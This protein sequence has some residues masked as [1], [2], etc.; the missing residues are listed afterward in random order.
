VGEKKYGGAVVFD[1]FPVKDFREVVSFSGLKECVDEAVS[2]VIAHELRGAS[3]DF[4]RRVV[5]ISGNEVYQ[6]LLQAF[7][8]S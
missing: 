3:D 4:A 1:P 6:E 2:L 8:G 5:G 7:K